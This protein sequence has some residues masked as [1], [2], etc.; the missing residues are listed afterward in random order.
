MFPKQM[1]TNRHFLG[2]VVFFFFFPGQ[3]RWRSSLDVEIRIVFKSMTSQLLVL[4]VR[5]DAKHPL[6]LL[7]S[8]QTQPDSGEYLRVFVHAAPEL[9]S[10]LGEQRL[11]SCQ[12]ASANSTYR[13]RGSKAAL[14]ERR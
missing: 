13:R 2:L 3:F 9:F 10:L 8:K 11:R 7:N 14:L 1:H 12:R 5:F 6:A 4:H